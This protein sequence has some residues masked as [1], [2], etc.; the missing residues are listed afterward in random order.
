MTKNGF[1]IHKI[2]HL[3][4]MNPYYPLLKLFK[5]DT[6]YKHI[7]IDQN[8]DYNYHELENLSFRSLSD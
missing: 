8:L 2:I 7:F 6:N 3:R 5:F 1:R 4:K